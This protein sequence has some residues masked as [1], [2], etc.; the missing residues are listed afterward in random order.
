[1][2]SEFTN[3]DFAVFSWREF[4]MS[5]EKLTISGKL[6]S[7]QKQA[8]H[9]PEILKAEISHDTA[10]FAGSISDGDSGSLFP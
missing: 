4:S 10:F 3:D 5:D 2:V 6:N 8:W 9:E 7:S 1:M